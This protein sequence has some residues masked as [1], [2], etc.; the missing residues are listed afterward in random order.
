MTLVRLGSV[1]H[2]FDM[3]QG[4][5]YLEGGGAGPLITYMELRD[6]GRG[7]LHRIGCD[8]SPLES[9]DFEW[10]ATSDTSLELDPADGEQYV[11][12]VTGLAESQSL[13]RATSA[14]SDL[15]VSSGGSEG[16]VFLTGRPGNV[17]PPKEG[18][19][20]PGYSRLDEI[21]ICDER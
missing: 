21:P 10:T 16:M 17:P 12:S 2:Q 11:P 14:D 4:F 9:L 19:P 7:L 15:V 5:Y 1:T 20:M 13:E 3:D 18:C 6:G 8:F